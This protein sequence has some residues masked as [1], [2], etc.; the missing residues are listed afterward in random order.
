[1][2]IIRGETVPKPEKYTGFIVIGDGMHDEKIMKALFKRFNDKKFVLMPQDRPSLKLIGSIDIAA[3]LI[4]RF[5]RDVLIVID[6]EHFDETQLEAQLKQKFSKVELM[7][8][9]GAFYTINVMKGTKT[10]NLYIAIMGAK[11][12]IEE[13]EAALIREYYGEVV[14]PAKEEIKSAL[15]RHHDEKIYDL[16]EKLDY[17][18]LRRAFPPSFIDFLK[19]WSRC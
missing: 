4:G 5:G 7:H 16:I 15:K 14:K 6:R 13:V 11:K 18:K 1:M 17:E 8:K 3:E 2:K 12:S 19:K 9:D 10:A